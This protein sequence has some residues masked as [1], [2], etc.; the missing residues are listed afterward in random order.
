MKRLAS[1]LPGPAGR[2]GRGGGSTATE[3]A[4]AAAAAAVP[5]AAAALEAAERES[6]AAMASLFLQ[7]GASA[8]RALCKALVISAP[9]KTLSAMSAAVKSVIGVTIREV[10][11][12][13][14]DFV[15]PRLVAV[16]ERA[17]HA[18]EGLWTLRLRDP[19]GAIQGVL[20]T[21]VAKKHELEG[22]LTP[23]TALALHNVSVLL[24]P[25]SLRRSLNLHESS[26]LAVFPASQAWGSEEAEADAGV[27][28]GVGVGVGVVAVEDEYG[29]LAA[30]AVRSGVPEPNPPGRFFFDNNA[31]AH[32]PAPAP[33]PAAGPA[34]GVFAVPRGTA[35]KVARS[36]D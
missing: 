14:F 24:C 27:E 1:S 29:G 15:A 9:E 6:E 18:N 34:G 32:A 20:L 26:I 4:A 5:D 36:I 22:I 30:A 16:I 33:A 12:G 8:W 17:E 11:N 28:V 7:P 10:Q 3:A 23:G 35:A 21:S 2:V 19:S 31:P 25:V 13:R